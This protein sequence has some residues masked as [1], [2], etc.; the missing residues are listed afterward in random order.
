MSLEP[1]G[2]FVTKTNKRKKLVWRKCP[3]CKDEIRDVLGTWW[4]FE[5]H[6][7]IEKSDGQL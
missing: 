4:A 6:L 1:Y 5:D 2:M 7:R 3:I